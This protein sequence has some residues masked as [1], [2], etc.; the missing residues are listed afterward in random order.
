MV[1]DVKCDLVWLECDWLFEPSSCN[2]KSSSSC[3]SGLSLLNDMYETYSRLYHAYHASN[4]FSSSIYFSHWLFSLRI[5]EVK[6]THWLHP[7]IHPSI[8]ETNKQTTQAQ[9]KI[10]KISK[11]QF[12]YFQI[13]TS[14]SSPSPSS[15]TTSAT[16]SPQIK[17]WFHLF[18]LSSIYPSIHRSP[19][20][21]PPLP[22]SNSLNTSRTIPNQAEPYHT[23]PIKKTPN[24]STP[25]HSTPLT[26]YT[27]PHQT[28]LASHP[29]N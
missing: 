19:Q 3:G 16:S 2:C 15:P 26:P 28:T 21:T 22:S 12:I 24:Q 11:I 1:L 13:L 20:S 8:Q 27:K 7:S 25:L 17:F 18:T 6:G 5:I 4:H 29:T 23:I 9:H 10:S 14:S